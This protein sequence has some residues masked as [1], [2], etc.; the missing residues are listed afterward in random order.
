VTSRSTRAGWC[1]RLLSR[2]VATLCALGLVAAPTAAAAEQAEWRD[3]LERAAAAARELSYEGEA[4]WVTRAGEAQH[5]VT[6]DVRNNPSGMVVGEAADVTL[7]LGPDGDGLLASAE[8]WYV[9]LPPVESARDDLTRIT[10]KYDVVV[11][12][13]DRIVDRPCTVVEIHSRRDGELRERLWL[14][15]DSGL[16][17]RRETFEG[18]PEPVRLVA[19]LSLD[20]RV[21]RPDSSAARSERITAHGGTLSEREQGV[22]P[23]D[24]RGLAALREAGWVVPGALPGGFEPVGAFAV[25]SAESQPLQ[26]LYGDGLYV[27]SVFQQAGHPDWSTLP[28]GAEEVEGLGWKAYEWPGAV[29]RRIVWEAQGRTWSVV[30][31]APPQEMLTLL[32][33]L[34]QPF[35]PGLWQRL[36][37]GLGRLW[38]MVSP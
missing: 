16:L 26:L 30:G 8:G 25:S 2:L 24:E 14:D 13:S 35:E 12:G 21:R 17:L 34:P 18:S 9:P 32:H 31:D 4:I 5:V 29:P 1:P 3:V 36:R 33:A 38:S 23:V 10:D 15:D 27:V 19:Y 28:P 7:R 22:A 11:A 6:V 37:R 20:L